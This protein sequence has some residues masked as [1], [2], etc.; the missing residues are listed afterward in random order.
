[1]RL[2][3]YIEFSCNSFEK[4]MN[5]TKMIHFREVDSTDHSLREHLDISINNLVTKNWKCQRTKTLFFKRSCLSFVVFRSIPKLPR[6]ET[7]ASLELILDV[8][9]TVFRFLNMTLYCCKETKD[10]FNDEFCRRHYSCE[11]CLK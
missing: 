5:E 4:F 7:R 2:T 6:I 10:K 11:D 8:N 3:K 9:L 1:M